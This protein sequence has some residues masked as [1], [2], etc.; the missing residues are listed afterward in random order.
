MAADESTSL[1]QSACPIPG[2][3][4]WCECSRLPLQQTRWAMH[5]AVIYSFLSMAIHVKLFRAHSGYIRHKTFSFMMSLL[6]MSLGLRFCVSR[7]GGTGGGGWAYLYLVGTGRAIS[8]LFG[9]NG[10]R[11]KRSHLVGPPVPEFKAH[12]SATAG[13]HFTWDLTRCLL[14]GGCGHSHV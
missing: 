13:W 6:A 1:I 9:I 4:G 2:W 5:N 10:V 3:V 14:I 8:I 7:K 12:F 11:N